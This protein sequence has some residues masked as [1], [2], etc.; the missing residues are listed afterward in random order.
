M[1]TIYIFDSFGILSGSREVDEYGPMPPSSTPRQP[2]VAT[3]GKVA[4]WTGSAWGLVDKSTATKPPYD[5]ASDRVVVETRIKALRDA[6]EIAGVRVRGYWFHSDYKSLTKYLGLK[7]TARDVLAAGGTNMDFILEGGHVIPWST[8]DGSS[9][10][11][12]VSLAFELVAAVRTLQSIA[13]ATAKAH[14]AAMREVP[15]PLE[16]DFSTGWPTV[17]PTPSSKP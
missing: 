16:Y 9:V 13:F 6:V 2:P 12:T 4:R 10:P 11:V 3:A 8:L 15:F 5:P 17:F 14:I 1:I 7:D